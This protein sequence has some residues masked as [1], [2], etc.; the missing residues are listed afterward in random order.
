[1]WLA[2]L[3]QG[4]QWL[5]SD[6]KQEVLIRRVLSAC[7]LY[8]EL[9]TRNASGW[10]TQRCACFVNP[11]IVYLICDMESDLPSTSQLFCRTAGDHSTHTSRVSPEGN[12][13]DL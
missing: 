6:Y 1:M 7:V 3:E 12:D 11:I 13:D 4:Y 2:G 8:H 10:V 9:A 5:S